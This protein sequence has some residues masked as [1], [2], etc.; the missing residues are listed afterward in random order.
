[1]VHLDTSMWLY[2]V[3]CTKDELDWQMLD[4][5]FL[6]LVFPNIVLSCICCSN[7][8]LSKHSTKTRDFVIQTSYFLAFVIPAFIFPAL[9][10][11][12]SCNWHELINVW[13]WNCKDVPPWIRSIRQF[14]D[15]AQI[16]NS[17]V[18]LSW[19][20]CRDSLASSYVEQIWNRG[21]GV[22][23]QGTLWFL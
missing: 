17:C 6:T 1:M 9:T 7:T 12:I 4:R 20:Y 14:W 16:W 13:M 3:F 10:I 22:R 11:S 18:N 23:W 21:E 8:C 19:E 2:H 5:I 15:Y